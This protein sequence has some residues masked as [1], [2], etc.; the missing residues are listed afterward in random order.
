MGRFATAV[1]LRDLGDLGRAPG[2]RWRF[3]P[4]TSSSRSSVS[5]PHSPRPP[6][7]A[8]SAPGP[9]GRDRG[10]GQRAERVI[11]LVLVRALGL[12]LSGLVSHPGGVGGCLA[13]Q[14]RLARGA[15]AAT[16]PQWCR[17]RCSTTPR[18]PPAVRVLA[19]LAGTLVGLLP[20]TAAVVILGDALTGNINPL[21]V[22]VSVCTAALGIAGLS[23]ETR[24]YRSR[25]AAVV[26]DRTD[27]PAVT[28]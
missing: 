12:Q 2:S 27:A 11:A 20:G 5:A 28:G 26:T 15:V 21:L 23:Y 22:L 8:V 13:A 17:S 4:P 10:A 6:G 24:H 9:R 7:L 14:P 3:W 18:A 1:Q 19:S 16:D 25:H